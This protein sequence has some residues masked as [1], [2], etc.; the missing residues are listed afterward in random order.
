MHVHTH[1]Q[2]TNFSQD[3]NKIPLESN[4]GFACGLIVYVCVCV[5]FFLLSKKYLYQKKIKLPTFECEM[6]S[7][8]FTDCVSWPICIK[9]LNRYNRVLPGLCFEPF[10]TVV[11]F[12]VKNIL[13]TIINMQYSIPLVKKNYHFWMIARIKSIS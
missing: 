5:L 4:F 2:G 1:T 10:S 13:Q 6:H 3:A 9:L 7:F 12:K 8:I 11:N